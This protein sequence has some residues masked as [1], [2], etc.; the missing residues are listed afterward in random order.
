M[1]FNH[2]AVERCA[3]RRVIVAANSNPNRVACSRWIG[4]C[5]T[6]DNCSTPR[7]LGPVEH[8]PFDSVD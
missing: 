8:D 6:R 2:L 3:V 4:C 7:E 1:A 5:T